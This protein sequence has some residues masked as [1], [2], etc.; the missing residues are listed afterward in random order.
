MPSDSA[1]SASGSRNWATSA[2]AELRQ[3]QGLL[4]LPVERDLGFAAK[5]PLSVY[6]RNTRLDG[7]IGAWAL[8]APPVGGPFRAWRRGQFRKARRPCRFSRLLDAA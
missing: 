7:V 1:I 8:K 6:A 2:W 3:V 5:Y 4:G